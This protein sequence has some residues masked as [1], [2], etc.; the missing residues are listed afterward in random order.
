MVWDPKT[1]FQLLLF[2]LPRDPDYCFLSWLGTKLYYHTASLVF[3]HQ[4]FLACSLFL[5]GR[6]HSMPRNDCFAQC[7]GALVAI[8]NGPQ[9]TQKFFY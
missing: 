4:W 5:L 2:S 3:S 1:Q 7:V 9:N 8:Q 6:S